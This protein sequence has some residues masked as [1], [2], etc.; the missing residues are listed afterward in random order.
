MLG[1]GVG[2]KDAAKR[3]SQEVGRAR[4]GVGKVS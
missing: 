2:K 3:H 1:L 4:K